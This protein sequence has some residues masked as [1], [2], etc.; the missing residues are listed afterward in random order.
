MEKLHTQL[1]T[2]R[3]TDVEEFGCGTLGGHRT[4]M[5]DDLVDSGFTV[6][7][8][9]NGQRDELQGLPSCGALGNGSSAKDSLARRRALVQRDA[10][11]MVVRQ[12]ERE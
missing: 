2:K 10:A 7:E 6:W 12:S 3:N 11:A 5:E 4:K 9:Q 8:R 1:R